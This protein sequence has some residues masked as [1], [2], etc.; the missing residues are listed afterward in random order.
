MNVTSF[1]LILMKANLCGFPL[2]EK[3]LYL[4]VNNLSILINS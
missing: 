2:N 1:G 4:T 3:L